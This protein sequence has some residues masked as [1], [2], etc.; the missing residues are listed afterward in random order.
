MCLPVSVTP[1]VCL[2][3]ENGMDMKRQWTWGRN[4]AGSGEWEERAPR[5]PEKGPFPTRLYTVKAED[6]ALSP[7][8]IP[9]H[10]PATA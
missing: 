1:P 8:H 7:T 4:R 6:S 2:A 10:L 9:P 5:G 3:K